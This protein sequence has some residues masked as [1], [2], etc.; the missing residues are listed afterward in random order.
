MEGALACYSEAIELYRASSEIRPGD[1]IVRKPRYSGFAGTNLDGMLKACNTKYCIYTGVA[2][3]VC[4]ESTL[5]DG[6]FL[7]YWPILVSDAVDNA[8]PEITQQA[9]LWNVERLFGWVIDTE[10]LLRCISGT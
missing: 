4:V 8:G 9:T 1:M 3:N 2:T 6:Y 7:D 5:R 10:N